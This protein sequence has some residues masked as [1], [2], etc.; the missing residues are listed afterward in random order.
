MHFNSSKEKKNDNFSDVIPSCRTIYMQANSFS[1][2][3]AF[4]L[5]FSKSLEK[6]K[7]KAMHWR[8]GKDLEQITCIMHMHKHASLK[9]ILNS[10]FI[11]DFVN[12]NLILKCARWKKCSILF[13]LNNI[14]HLIVA[15]M[16]T[17]VMLNYSHF[18]F[19]NET[20]WT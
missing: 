20:H 3:D 2:N 11:N 17:Y 9:P 6:K 13:F 5:G 15:C 14:F 19:V 4:F 16:Y 8:R 12:V 10:D 1:R 7:W 18:F